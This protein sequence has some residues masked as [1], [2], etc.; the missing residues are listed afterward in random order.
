MRGSRMNGVCHCIS[1]G[2]LNTYSERNPRQRQAG[3]PLRGGVLQT[4]ARTFLIRPA[5]SI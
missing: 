5:F 1:V 4:E 3:P 2:L